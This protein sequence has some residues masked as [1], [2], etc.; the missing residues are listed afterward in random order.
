MSAMGEEQIYNINDIG[1]W[2]QQVERRSVS[3]GKDIGRLMTYRSKSTMSNALPND[4][5]KYPKRPMPMPTADNLKQSTIAA[6]S[7]SKQIENVVTQMRD[8]FKLGKNLIVSVM[9]AMGEEQI[10]TVKDIGLWW[11]QVERRAVSLGDG[12]NE[13]KDLIVSVMS[14]M[15]EEQIYTVKDIGGGSK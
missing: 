7:S 2:W 9:S 4:A 12:F 6:T 8:G 3:R 13:G 1:W 10:C 14:A 15:G 5:S 11:Q